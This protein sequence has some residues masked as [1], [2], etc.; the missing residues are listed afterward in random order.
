MSVLLIWGKK[1]DSCIVIAYIFFQEEF[2]LKY[3]GTVGC[4]VC[5]LLSNTFFKNV[6]LFFFCGSDIWHWRLS[7]L[8]G[9]PEAS[10]NPCSS[11][12]QPAPC[13]CTWKQQ[14]TM[15]QFLSPFHLQDRSCGFS[16]PQDRQRSE[17]GHRRAPY[18]SLSCHCLSNK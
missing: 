6:F 12:S 5:K 18:F 17:P 16:L 10:L 7:H 2:T 14:Q 15:T 3:L 9:L 11:V 13:Q 1:P 4:D 8:L